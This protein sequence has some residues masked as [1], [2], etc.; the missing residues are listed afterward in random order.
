MAYGRLD[1]FF[2]DGLIQTFGLSERKVSVG[3]SN[4]NHITLDNSTIS[5]QHFI[6]TY[7]GET[8]ALTDLGSANGSYVDGVK[9]T[10][11]EPRSLYG[12]EEIQIGNLR[13][14]YHYIDDTPTQPMT[15]LDETTQRIELALETFRI[16]LQ[17]PLQGVSP[18][19]HISAELSI[20]NTTAEEVRYHVEVSGP[21]K[22]WIRVERPR[23]IVSPH[24]NTFTLIN[25]KPVR[26]SDSTP[27]PYPVKIRVYPENAPDNALETHFV[28]NVL[29][30]SAFAMA[31]KPR[32]ITSDQRTQLHLQ[33]QGSAPL[34]VSFKGH[35]PENAL[36]FSFTP[37][38]ITLAP[39]QRA[40]IQTEVSAKES[41]LMGTAQQY[42]FDLIVRSGD[43]AAFTGALQGE[44]THKPSLSKWLPMLI[45]GAIGAGIL[46]LV[47]LALLFTQVPRNP[48][49][50][51]FRLNKVQIARGEPLLVTWNGENMGAVELLFNETPV[52]TGNDA[53]MPLLEV[54]TTGFSG[55]VTVRLQ[56]D[57]SGQVSSQNHTIRIYEPA[58]IE[59]FQVSPSQMMRYVVQELEVSWL[60][61]GAVST[62]LSGLEGFNSSTLSFAGPSANVTGLAGIPQGPLTLTLTGQDEMGTVVEST[63]TINV[64]NPECTPTG[65]SV[66]LH[67]GPDNRHQVVGTILEG[68]SAV[69]NGQDPGGQWLRVL[70]LSGGVSG[71]GQRSA[72]TCN[73]FNVGDLQMITDIPAVPPSP[74]PSPTT[75]PTPRPTVTPASPAITPTFAG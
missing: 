50:T 11:Q 51:D 33:N 40:T 55:A 26:R 45:L 60:V 20:A 32:A 24:D 68:T 56:A 38:Q 22:T 37:P 30:Y 27:G 62:Q 67:A 46:G 59:S 12:G 61:S 63:F 4:D 75:P 43:H 53:H 72:F 47:L 16:D 2:P 3:R 74:V 19:A 71:W 18:G 52:Y 44:F 5:R 25:F 6:I 42:P 49:I 14:I 65:Q 34:P 39:G 69:V 48:E 23:P 36:K 54:D 15:P 31:M 9:L 35:N 21:P 64:I 13:I 41:R 73:G 10:S 28:L 17:E 66:P 58:V 29:P 57:N 7:D 8:V 70:G 1:V